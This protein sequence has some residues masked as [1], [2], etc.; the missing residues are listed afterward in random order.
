MSSNNDFEIENG[1]L[2]KYTGAGG[3]V[4]IPD[5]V[6]SI[7]D[8]AFS[9]CE[10]LTSVTMPNSVTSIED[11]AFC[12]CTSLTSIVIP[13]GVTTIGDYMFHSCKSLTSVTIPDSVSSSGKCVFVDCISLTN[14]TIPNHVT[15][16]GDWTFY[17]CTNLISIAIPDGVTSI[18]SGVWNSCE[19]LTSVKIPDSLNSIGIWAFACCKSLTSIMIPKRVINIVE[20]AFW[21]CESLTGIKIAI[22]DEKVLI[23]GYY[24]EV[25]KDIVAV[26]EMLR[27]GKMDTEVKMP[28]CMKF[29]MAVEMIDL[30]DNAEAKAYVK[31]MLTKGV[32]ML[33]DNGNL[34]LIQVLLGKTDFVTKKNVDKYIQYAI[35]QKQQE[36][37]LDLICYKNAIMA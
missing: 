2:V 25:E 14:I 22:S 31:K 7:G 35:D 19:R 28:L 3:D 24:A 10:G 37:Y 13:N 1:V 15:S 33:I 20:A 30:H 34:Q 8:W 11:H 21:G 4:V 6:T 18:G 29:Q 27:T 16:I 17:K 23:V 26:K 36:I 32:K 5:G 9:R 12:E